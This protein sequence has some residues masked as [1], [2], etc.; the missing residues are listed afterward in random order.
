MKRVE[1]KMQVS[2]K[3]K[4]TLISLGIMAGATCSIGFA[5]TIG[6]SYTLELDNNG[7]YAPDQE[8]EVHN[9]DL[10]DDLK[11]N[12]ADAPETKA[13]TSAQKVKNVP[14]TVVT[15][16][17]NKEAVV[18]P[19]SKENDKVMAGQ[20]DNQDT[21]TLH[22]AQVLAKHANSSTEL[23]SN[24]KVETV[25]SSTNAK[26]VIVEQTVA[27]HPSQKSLSEHSV[28]ETSKVKKDK[29]LKSGKKLS[30]VRIKENTQGTKKDEP[31]QKPV[32]EKKGS[33]NPPQVHKAAKVATP[34]VS[35]NKV[36][37]NEKP[38]LENTKKIMA[39]AVPKKEKPKA[40][41]AEK[42]SVIAK[43]DAKTMKALKEENAKR[44]QALLNKTEAGD[45]IQTP[46]G[47]KASE[48]TE[49]KLDHD[50][51]KILQS[52]KMPLE[53]A[54]NVKET[55]D[56]LAN[57]KPKHM[58][59]AN[60]PEHESQDIIKA[61]ST[62]KVVYGNVVAYLLEHPAHPYRVYFNFDEAAIKDKQDNVLKVFIHDYTKQKK[63]N[64][65][66]LVGRTDELGSDKYN[67]NL[68]LLRAERVKE[69]MVHRYHLSPE[70]IYTF[71][72][73]KGAAL[74]PASDHMLNRSV[75]MLFLAKK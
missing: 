60:N 13:V 59:V 73:G 35:N 18:L 38:M 8:I 31:L 64:E 48:G 14:T 66:V 23:N 27:T 33:I 49:A 34:V 74:S 32:T 65:I 7:Y 6:K 12:I 70:N 62:Q 29:P 21:V 41:V 53:P 67:Y 17:E 50:T 16:A 28:E 56:V 75:T 26:N 45:A 57:V 72:Y 42:A 47:L 58:T 2:S 10:K 1:E 71:S 40:V 11:I 63:E 39:N 20:L 9:D 30:E 61:L 36:D 4:K 37:P 44:V 51:N 43:D 68:G 3:F 19:K 5:D 25:P 15:K 52:S 46:R 54:N 22:T 55:K 24:K 69:M